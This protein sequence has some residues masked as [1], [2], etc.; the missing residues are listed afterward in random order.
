MLQS[1]LV[2]STEEGSCGMNHVASFL[3][4]VCSPLDLCL[5]SESILCP[6]IV[7]ILFIC[8]MH[9]RLIVPPSSQLPRASRIGIL[10]QGVEL[11]RSQAT[12]QVT[13]SEGEAPKEQGEKEHTRM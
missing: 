13:D 9:C 11:A 6:N 5:E 4:E 8:N 10:Q 12:A 3:R 2:Y 1:I 7:M